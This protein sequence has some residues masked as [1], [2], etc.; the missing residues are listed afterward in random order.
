[1]TLVVRSSEFNIP[2]GELFA[3][4]MD[5][6]NLVKISPPIA[7]VKLLGEPG[8]AQPGDLQVIEM[9]AGPFRQEWHARI[10]RVVP[11][12]LI[13]D[14]QEQG[15]FRKW[16]HQHRI[17][18]LPGGRSRLTDAVAFRLLPTPAG[19]F[20]EYFAVRPFIVAM[21]AWRHHKTRQL[22]GHHNSP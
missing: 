1:M 15:P 17:A 21:F 12:Q 6:A 7:P 8:P 2:A 11:G 5:A 18:E 22:L 16:R 10:L 9:G 4:H 3:F 13:E 14:I 19:E 20:I